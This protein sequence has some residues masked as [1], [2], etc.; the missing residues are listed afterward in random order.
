M[1]LEEDFLATAADTLAQNMA[2]ILMT[3]RQTG[4]D[5][6]FYGYLNQTGR[7]ERV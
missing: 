3:K 5:L 4:E 1:T 6:G 2:R 7:K